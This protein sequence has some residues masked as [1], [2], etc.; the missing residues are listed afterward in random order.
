MLGVSSNKWYHKSE[1]SVENETSCTQLVNFQRDCYGK[2]SKPRVGLYT[3]ARKFRPIQRRGKLG[4]MELHETV[5]A[6]E[7]KTKGGNTKT[8]RIS[9][10]V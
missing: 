3:Q 2:V 7:R 10:W 8:L 5:L 9:R 4:V 6:E 1:V